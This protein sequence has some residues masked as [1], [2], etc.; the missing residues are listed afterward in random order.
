MVTVVLETFYCIRDPK[1]DFS[2]TFS[3]FTYRSK[4]SSAYLVGISESLQF[5]AVLCR[6]LIFHL[7]KQRRE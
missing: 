7:K 3:P 6:L 2:E 1:S 4:S 5:N